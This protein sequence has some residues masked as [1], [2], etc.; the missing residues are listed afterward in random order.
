MTASRSRAGWRCSSRSPRF[1]RG[2][3][4]PFRCSPRRRPRQGWCVHALNPRQRQQ[5]RHRPD[6][7]VNNTGSR[8]STSPTSF[9]PEHRCRSWC[10]DHPQ[11]H[12]EGRR[13]RDRLAQAP[14]ADAVGAVPL[15]RP[16][17]LQALRRRGPEL[18]ALSNVSPPTGGTSSATAASRSWRRLR[19]R[20][21][22]EH[23]LQRRREEGADQDDGQRRRH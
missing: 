21:P 13:H 7:S 19:L 14:V 2:W 22:E 16:G 17:R 10:A 11:K 1:R 18:H 9:H 5:G 12:P 6:L 4:R 15:H 20:D 8:K 3:R 23:L